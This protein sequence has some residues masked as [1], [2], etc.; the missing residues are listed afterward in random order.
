M[1]TKKYSTRSGD[2]AYYVSRATEA[3]PWIVFLPGLTTDHRLFAPQPASLS[4][5][6]N[7]I[8][9]DAPRHG[10]SR[11]F[12]GTFRLDDAAKWLKEI[13]DKETSIA[14]GQ[15]TADA[16][17]NAAPIAVDARPRII[18]AGQSLGAYIAQVYLELFPDQIGGFVSIDSTPLKRAYYKNWELTALKRTYWMYR[19]IPSRLLLAAWGARGCAETETGREY[20]R[21]I[22]QSYGK[23][24]YCAL[25]DEGFRALATAV[26]AERACDIA[27]PALILCEE[28]DKAGSTKRYSEQWAARESLPIIWIPRAGHNSTL[29]APEFVTEAIRNFMRSI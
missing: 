12:S 16:T 2:I 8:A 18:L 11:P 9:W 27:C 20:M 25:A 21:S 22:I 26:E 4:D 13:I 28:K 23:L 5:E 14:P 3:A 6:F 24:E 29:D 17:L 7:L 10:A 19:V 15:P 1:E